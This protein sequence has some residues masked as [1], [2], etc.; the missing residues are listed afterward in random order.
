MTQYPVIDK[1]LIAPE[2]WER[3]KLTKDYIV[4]KKIFG[5]SSV[6][7]LIK[8][9]EEYGLTQVIKNFLEIP[10]SSPNFFN[11]IIKKT[12]PDWISEWQ[13][14]H[15]TLFKYVYKNYGQFRKSGEDVYF[16]NIAEAE[17]LYKI[18]KGNAVSREIYEA[19]YNLSNQ[20][21]CINKQDLKQVCYFL[22]NTHYTFIRIHPFFDGNGRIARVITDQLSLAFGYIPIIAS[23]PRNNKISKAEYHKAI[24]QCAKLKSCIKLSEWIEN[25]LIEKSNK[26]S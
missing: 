4:D 15:S 26:L 1:S 24:R 23:F 17:D 7:P 13:N 14:M 9:A 10:S 18:P 3:Y 20:I 21:P 5:I 11:D 2:L 22:A 8:E 6:H 19:S 25:K 12:G 16:G